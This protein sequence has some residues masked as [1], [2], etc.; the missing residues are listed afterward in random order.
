MPDITSNVSFDTVAREWRCKWSPDADKASLTALQD[1]LTSHL[2]AIK[3]SGAT[4][5][6]V[7]CGGC[8]DFKVIMSLPADDFGTWDAAGFTPEAEFLDAAKAIDGVTDVETQTYT[9]MPM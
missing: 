6:R 5:Q 7:V 4:V 2:D 9:L 1:L 3:A 8:M